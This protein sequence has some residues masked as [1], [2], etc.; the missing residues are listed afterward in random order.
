MVWGTTLSGE[1]RLQQQMCDCFLRTSGWLSEATPAVPGSLLLVRTTS[2]LV[3]DDSTSVGAAELP[4]AGAFDGVVGGLNANNNSAWSTAAQAYSVDGS[5]TTSLSPSVMLW[6]SVVPCVLTAIHQLHDSRTCHYWAVQ[7]AFIHQLCQL[8]AP[9]AAHWQLLAL[10]LLAALC[11]ILLRH[12][13]HVAIPVPRPRPCRPAAAWACIMALCLWPPAQHAWRTA[14]SVD[15][16]GA[17]HLA[18]AT[19]KEFSFTPATR[20]LFTACTRH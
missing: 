4:A 17:W 20:L 15:G 13:V 2:E 12:V 10:P 3:D 7:P 19:C 5:S 11:S 9:G 1:A 14:L 8:A 18:G 16:A 6:V